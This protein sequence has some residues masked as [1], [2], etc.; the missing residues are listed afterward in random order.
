MSGHPGSLL[1][2]SHQLVSLSKFL[3]SW[4]VNDIISER[5]EFL[6][7]FCSTFASPESLW[8]FLRTGQ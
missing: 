2:D 8:F 6:K 5:R 1:F 7:M 3:I 4:D